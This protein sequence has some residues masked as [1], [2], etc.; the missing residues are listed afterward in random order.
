MARKGIPNRRAQRERA[1]N[2][3][4]KVLYSWGYLSAA[5]VERLAPRRAGNRASCSCE[6]C[7]PHK[8]PKRT[9]SLQ[10]KRA[11]ITHKEETNT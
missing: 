10:E 6:M 2:K 7:K 4:K 11:I 9:L 8:K 3:A 5:E 1:L